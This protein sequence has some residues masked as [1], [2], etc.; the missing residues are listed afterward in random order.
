[1]II[2]FKVKNFLS[3]KEEQTLSF[4]ATADKTLEEYFVVNKPKHRLLKMALIFGPNAS[5]KTNILIALD[6]LRNFILTRPV[7][8]TIGT[9]HIPFLLDEKSKNE[10]GVFDLSFYAGE[11]LYEYH[12]EINNSFIN[13]EKLTYYP[14]IRPAVIFNRTFDREKD[15]TQ[16]EFGS[17]VALK[18]AEKTLIRGNTIRNMSVF[19]AYAKLNIEFPE[20]DGAYKYF[21][22]KIPQVVTPKSNL[23]NW[24]SEK[25]EQSNETKTFVLN[26]LNNADF[27][28]SNINIE[29]KESTI[30]D[31]V[32]RNLLS[33][34]LTESVKEKLRTEEVIKIKT[35]SFS[36]RTE[37]DK[38]VEFP[39]ELES[40]GTNRFF[41]LGGVLHDAL[42]NDKCLLIDEIDSSLHP[43]LVIHLINTFLVNS[44]EAQ[45]VCTTHD[46]TILSEQDNLRKDVIWFTNKDGEG[47]TEL[48]S[49]ADFKHRKELSF[50]NAYK[51]GKFGAKPNLGSVFLKNNG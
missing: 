36:H 44:K 1:M 14:S 48:Y 43:D 22:N 42:R 13:N 51:A 20:L 32:R 30:N 12:L 34:N 38:E 39:A 29:T 40:A 28:I 31:D 49:M 19:A 10:Q 5:G 50:I 33:T 16:I 4:E 23:R 25:V 18:A 8:K 3:I 7:D 6:F 45:L 21:L 41:G 27:N 46:L 35:L 24:T 2:E 9:T 17:L 26:L 15:L 37:H 47:A 11:M